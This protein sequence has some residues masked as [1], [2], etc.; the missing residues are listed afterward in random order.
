MSCH[1][2]FL[3]SSYVSLT[4]KRMQSVKN[5]SFDMNIIFIT[6]VIQHATIKFEKVGHDNISYL[7][8]ALFL[9]NCIQN[10]IYIWDNKHYLHFHG[11]NCTAFIYFWTTWFFF[12]LCAVHPVSVASLQ[13]WGERR[14]ICNL[15]FFYASF[16]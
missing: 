15:W 12:W 7:I 6:N 11:L 1:F 14:H 9:N 2:I 10:I 3:S 8:S 13:H 5:M 16:Q 4:R